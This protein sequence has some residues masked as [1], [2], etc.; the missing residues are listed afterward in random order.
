MANN[1]FSM[2]SDLIPFSKKKENP[3]LSETLGCRVIFFIIRSGVPRAQ[4]AKKFSLPFL[5]GKGSGGAKPQKE[6][7]NFEMI[8]MFFNDKIHIYTL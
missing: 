3:R 5:S 7:T 2:S 6:V 1:T 4:M 8:F